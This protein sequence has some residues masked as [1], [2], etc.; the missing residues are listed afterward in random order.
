MVTLYYDTTTRQDVANSLP[1]SGEGR[2]VMQM[3]MLVTIHGSFPLTFV[4][5][6]F[7]SVE[8]VDRQAFWGG[9]GPGYTA[10]I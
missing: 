4:Q 9:L 5:K 7:V 2:R 10:R 8:V 3:Y 6:S 1:T